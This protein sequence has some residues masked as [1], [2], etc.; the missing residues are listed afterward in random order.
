MTGNRT[1]AFDLNQ[2]VKLKTGIA[3]KVL[4]RAPDA[5]HVATVEITPA[6]VHRFEGAKLGQ[7]VEVAIEVNAYQIEFAGDNG[8]PDTAWWQEDMLV[9]G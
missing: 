7:A 1:Y 3:G 4:A 8:R 5:D 9:K 2:A 6:N